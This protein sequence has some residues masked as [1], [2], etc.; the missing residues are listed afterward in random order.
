MFPGVHVPSLAEGAI[1]LERALL[2]QSP[3]EP[4]PLLLF[5]TFTALQTHKYIIHHTSIALYTSFSTE[6]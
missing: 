3:P 1:S 4:T 5:Y 2:S 6:K